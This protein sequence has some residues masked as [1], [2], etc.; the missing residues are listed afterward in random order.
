MIE[1]WKT[2][3]PHLLTEIADLG[4]SVTAELTI[5]HPQMTGMSTNII[6]EPHLVRQVN[7]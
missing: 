7:A 6:L 1:N 2:L 4:D 3:S 5:R